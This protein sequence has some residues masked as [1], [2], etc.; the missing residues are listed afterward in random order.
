LIWSLRGRFL[1]PAP[2]MAP[3][4]IASKKNGF[5]KTEINTSGLDVGPVVYGSVLQNVFDRTV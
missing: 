5:S 4:I 2:R 3:P 1:S